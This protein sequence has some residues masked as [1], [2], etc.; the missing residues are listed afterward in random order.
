MNPEK[1]KKTVWIINQF[2]GHNRSGWGERHFYF[3]KYWKEEYEVVLISGSYNHMFTELPNVNKKF[4]KEVVE[5]RTF[6]WIKTPTY[7]AESI[8]RFWSFIVFAFRSFFVPSST[9]GRPDIILV[10]SMPIFPILSGFWL[11]KK[12]NASK[13]IFEI[14]D[15]WPLTLIEL[16]KKSPKHP[17]VR[18]I[19][20]FERFGYKKSDVIVS[21][22]PNA[23]DHF[24]EVAQAGHKM[25]YIP[26]GLDMEA[27]QKM[28]VP[29][30][31][32]GAIPDD[33]FVIGYTGTIGLA[34]ALEH[35]VEAALILKNDPRFHFVLIGDGYLKSK[36]IESV[37]GCE[38]ITFF[39]KVKKDQIATL[40]EKFDVCFVGRSGS[41]L[42]RHG[43]S[44]NKYFDYMLAS[45]PVLD[46]N[47]RIKD[48]IELS[49]G[50]I[51]V[52]PDSSQC[53]VE[54]IETLFGMTQEKREELGKLGYLYVTQNHSI[55]NL[56]AEYAAIFK[57]N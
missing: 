8:L 44:A 33:K 2:A 49:G 32:L 42:F 37:E 50:G 14:R 57:Q 12:Y 53:I 46:S 51:I 43:V 24:D 35:F 5:G 36:L 25:K 18:F 17:A 22:L 30:E 4:T 55:S 56:A 39:D 52:E 11:K 38:N 34:N 26:N 41:P 19:G 40:L 21:L 29:S 54:G 15:I 31:I 45:K 23:K 10:S 16:G 20:W 3:S 9:F 6:C 28:E 27:L 47:N 1:K 48:P 7:K 13:L